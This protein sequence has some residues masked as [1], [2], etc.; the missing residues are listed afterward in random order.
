MGVNFS[1]KHFEALTPVWGSQ[2][3]SRSASAS[4]KA[5][6]RGCGWGHKALFFR[7]P[8][9]SLVLGNETV[10]RKLRI[11]VHDSVADNLLTASLSN[12]RMPVPTL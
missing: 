1:T 2:M 12:K 10:S 8:K 5:W 3:V 11:Q 6:A 7:F 9:W 4:W